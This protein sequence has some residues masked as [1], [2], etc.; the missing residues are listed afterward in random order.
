MKIQFDS[1][2]QFQL[3]AIQSIVDIFEGQPISSNA[4]DI[5]FDKNDSSLSF[6]EKGVGNNLVLTNEQLLKNINEVQQ[7]NGVK[8]S[9]SL[10]SVTYYKSNDY[11]LSD[12]EKEPDFIKASLD[13]ESSTPYTFKFSNNYTIE[14]ETGT[15]KTY[16]YLRTIYELNKVYGS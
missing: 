11:S 9:D 4:F 13:E 7:R 2:Q 14:M 10:E 12:Y 5:S 8:V 1:S 6:S 16:T 15:G 3:D